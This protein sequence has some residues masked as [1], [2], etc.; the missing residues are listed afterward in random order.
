MD[1]I[2]IP[3]KNERRPPL[4]LPKDPEPQP[5]VRQDRSGPEE[6]DDPPKPGIG[7]RHASQT[8]RES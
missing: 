1:D 6:E 5:E 3:D 4:D 7:T 8:K 2:E